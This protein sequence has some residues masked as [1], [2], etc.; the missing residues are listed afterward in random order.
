MPE[1]LGTVS[2]VEKH[3]GVYSWRKGTLY[4]ALVARLP[5]PPTVIPHRESSLKKT[6]SDRVSYH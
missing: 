6:Q 1:C 2:L 5:L 3:F 4:Y